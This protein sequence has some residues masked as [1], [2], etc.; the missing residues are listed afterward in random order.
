MP[1]SP[2][3]DVGLT[4]GVGFPPAI[5]RLQTCP[6]NFMVPNM[7]CLPKLSP[8]GFP[9]SFRL[10]GNFFSEVVFFDFCAEKDSFS[11]ASGGP[12]RGVLIVADLK[13][14]RIS[15]DTFARQS[16]LQTKAR[17]HSVNPITTTTC[18]TEK[19]QQKNITLFSG[20]KSRHLTTTHHYE[21]RGS[22]SVC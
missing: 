11:S 19:N 4:C 20:R 8:C 13:Q 18:A 14:P 16:A 6:T 15:L 22:S 3:S 9:G 5:G 7:C 17:I 1:T 21:V 12:S 2:Y 10:N